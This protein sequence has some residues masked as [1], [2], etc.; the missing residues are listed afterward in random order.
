MTRHSYYYDIKYTI[1]PQG[2]G[3]CDIV[4]I[5]TQS[6]CSTRLDSQNNVKFL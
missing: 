5:T 4:D 3:R 2:I 1:V 6:T